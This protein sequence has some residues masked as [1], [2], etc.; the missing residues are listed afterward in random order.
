M[1]TTD[2]ATAVGILNLPTEIHTEILQYLSQDLVDQVIASSALPIWGD[3][4]R[5]SPPLQ[6]S[7]YIRFQSSWQNAVAIHKAIGQ[8]SG[9]F[10]LCC[11]VRNGAIEK[12]SMA[13]KPPC[14]LET[15]RNVDMLMSM[16][17]MAQSWSEID[18]TGSFI[19]DEHFLLPFEGV[20]ARDL[21]LSDKDIPVS[22]LQLDSDLRTT[23][24]KA[25]I[26]RYEPGASSRQIYEAR[27][28]RSRKF[29]TLSIF[30]SDT[31][32]MTLK[33]FL[34]YIVQRSDSGLQKD[35]FDI[36]GLH[37]IRVQTDDVDDV[38]ITVY[39]PRSN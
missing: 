31:E 5:D 14:P 35:K 15:A 19:L 26:D 25:R 9:K 16:G 23:F 7:R 17:T 38:E 34:Q 28:N 29:R 24:I 18:I 22:K 4:L 6:R 37:Y 13:W 12:Y 21:K 10:V 2:R 33:S 11:A 32:D 3:I 20:L 30:P 27:S 8:S 36:G 1:R 39:P